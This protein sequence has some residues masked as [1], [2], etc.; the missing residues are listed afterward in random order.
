[1]HCIVAW[2]IHDDSIHHNL[3]NR[4]ML[5]CFEGYSIAQILST[6]FVV[7]IPDSKEYVA[8]HD[9][10][11]KVAQE[12]EGKVEFIMSPLMRDGQYAGYFEKEK[13]NQMTDKTSEEEIAEKG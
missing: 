5:D 9:K 7:E 13:W 4:E 11:L 8:L 2:E 12:R 10:F 1:M 6:L 3:L